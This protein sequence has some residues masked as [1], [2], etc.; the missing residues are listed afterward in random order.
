MKIKSLKR[1][2][3]VIL[4]ICSASHPL[5]TAKAVEFQPI[6]EGYYLKSFHVLVSIN[7]DR[8]LDVTEVITADFVEQKHGIFRTIPMSGKMKY[9]AG[10][11]VK[12]KKYLAKI[13]DISVDDDVNRNDIPFSIS[14]N[15]QDFVIKIGDSK[16]EIT[17]E[18]T[19]RIKY[20]Y[21]IQ[22]NSYVAEDFFAYNLIGTG[23]DTSINDI[24]YQIIMPDSIEEDQICFF[25]GADGSKNSSDIKYTISDKIMKG[26]LNRILYPGEGLTLQM[27]IPKGYFQVTKN[28]FPVF[29]EG[30]FTILSFLMLALWGIWGR[31]RRNRIGE[32]AS[33]VERNPAQVSYILNGVVSD[34]AVS[35]M[36]LY[37]AEKGY[38]RIVEEEK[39]ILRLIKMRDMEGEQ[40]EYEKL[41]FD[42]IFNGRE[43]V[44]SKDLG[45]EFYQT[46]KDFKNAVNNEFLLQGIFLYDRRATK[47]RL[48]GYFL[49]AAILVVLTVFAMEFFNVGLGGTVLTVVIAFFVAVISLLCSV[50]LGE[51]VEW[52]QRG[53]Y[54]GF[55]I[56]LVIYVATLYLFSWGVGDLMVDPLLYGVGGFCVGICSFCGA[57]SNRRTREGKALLGE[58]LSYY[59]YLE[60]GLKDRKKNNTVEA[61]NCQDIAY[62]YLFGL[63]K[64]WAKSFR[65]LNVSPPEWYVSTHAANYTPMYF[66]AGME[67]GMRSYESSMSSSSSDS[68]GGAG[69]GAGGGGGGSW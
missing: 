4:I 17:G 30:I 2:L 50:L 22:E 7:K 20:H 18:Q 31:E 45:K 46:V 29:L 66:L 39:Q 69:G 32:L 19:Y 54:K 47:V 41:M 24:T 12:E 27:Q 16:K 55:T 3:L 43:S 21:A 67:N 42:S 23:W 33:M 53:R 65:N 44:L 56:I 11:T 35:A 1:I 6:Y 26:E 10:N 8:S 36:L 9:Y 60:Q 62:Y 63:T 14:T 25:S 38:L 28:P 37:W 40:K 52:L 57:F 58:T 5:V 48:S 13:T 51:A 68:S 15:D 64:K 49:S 34:R 59:W 61:F